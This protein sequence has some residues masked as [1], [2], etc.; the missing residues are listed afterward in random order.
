V[1]RANYWGLGDRYNLKEQKIGRL[2]VKVM[3]INKDSEDG[4]ALLHWK[5][6]GSWVSSA[7][8]FALRCYGV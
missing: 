1:Q 6:P 7:G 8:D 4:Y 2:L 5:E 3:K